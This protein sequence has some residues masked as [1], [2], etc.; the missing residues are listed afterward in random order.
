MQQCIELN[1]AWNASIAEIRNK[2]L[3]A[4]L[5]ERQEFILNR[6]ELKENRDEQLRQASEKCVR[7]EK[8]RPLSI[9]V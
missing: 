1:N 3:D 4:K 8:V 9:F 2:R 5:N 7:R 6:L